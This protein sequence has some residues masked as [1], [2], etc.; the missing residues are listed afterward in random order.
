MNEH[1]GVWSEDNV[2]WIAIAKKCIA[3]QR[4][5]TLSLCAHKSTLFAQISIAELYAHRCRVSQGILSL[6]RIIEAIINYILI[7]MPMSW[8]R[9][10]SHNIKHVHQ[11]VKLY[12]WYVY[13]S[14]SWYKWYIIFS[15]IFFLW[16]LHRDWMVYRQILIQNARKNTHHLDR[17]LLGFFWFDLVKGLYL[18]Q[19]RS[20]SALHRRISYVRPPW[21][22]S[23]SIVGS[24]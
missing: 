13:A 3:I 20:Y 14:K 22:W 24:L 19:F 12:S 7:S 8:F 5:M 11:T 4:T 18:S 2:K 16:V 1:F 6:R 21:W 17:I 10:S 15:N 9:Y 23:H